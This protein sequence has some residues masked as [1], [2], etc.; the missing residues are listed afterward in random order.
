MKPEVNDEVFGLLRQCPY[1]SYSYTGQV[2][3][4]PAIPV[5]VSIEVAYADGENVEEVVSR[6]RPVF[7]AIQ[8]R[9]GIIRRAVANEQQPI[10]NECWT[11]TPDDELTMDEFLAEMTLEA[12]S[13][14]SDGKSTMSYTVGER[15]TDHTL[16]A[17]LNEQLEVPYV[18]FAG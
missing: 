11:E 13:I 5:E 10:Y 9:E 17:H 2:D 14:R 16:I 7:A 8:S 12:I 1:D 3:F 18:E 15:F 6:A 4:W